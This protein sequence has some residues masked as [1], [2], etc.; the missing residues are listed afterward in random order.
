M[1]IMKKA[2]SR[3]ERIM[4]RVSILV[5]L[6]LITFLFSS[7]LGKAQD[8][9]NQEKVC[10]FY[11][12]YIGCPNCAYTDPTVLSE[13]PEEY[14]KFV[15]IEYSWIGGQLGD[16]NS[17]FFGEYAQAYKTQAAVPQLFFSKDNTKLGRLDVPKA[18]QDIK[19]LDSNPCPLIKKR[20]A[21]E[22]LSLNELKAK[23]KIWA[24][25]RILIKLEE[26]SWLFQWNGKGLSKVMIG[27]ERI[28]NSLAKDL[29]FTSN[30]SATLKDKKF[31]I[32]SP[33]KVKFSGSA[34]PTSS[35]F[36][37]Y[38]E[39]ENAIK[40]NV[41]KAPSAAST[42]TKLKQPLPEGKE[43]K[44]EEVDL[45]LFGK[46]KTKK[47][48]IPLLTAIFA[49]ADGLTNPCGFFVLFFLAG[50]LL[51]LA[52]ARKR[53]FLVGSVFV[54]FFIIYYFLFMALLLNVFMLGK[55]LALLTTIAGLVCL[56]AGFLN[57][58]DYFF[59]GKGF[60]L[61]LS[62]KKK[63]KFAE[64]VENLSLAKSNSALIISSIIVASAISL[65]AIACTFG[66]PLAYT[67]V[68]SAKS[69]PPLLYYLYLV[70]YNL[71]YSVPMLTI[72]SIIA[73]TLGKGQFGEAWIKKLK[74]ISGFIILFLGF[75]LIW[76]YIL[77]EHIGFILS[78]MFL[79]LVVSA[80]IIFINEIL[81]KKIKL[82]K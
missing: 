4:L 28:S 21:W 45:P 70:F 64:R 51:G 23:P 16:P 53:I 62:E 39:F 33:Y 35:G 5:I 31:E 25:K 71:I 47:F 2:T 43:K 48:S 49:V 74:L 59:F 68:L 50:S 18:E 46:I 73:I 60:S 66:I 40:I 8:A 19:G 67:K 24:N 34:F 72:V 80:L 69:L 12:T 37:P 63:S 54:L 38:I 65:V 52:G 3:K 22:Q 14:S 15:V 32:V 75:V 55:K 36:V 42:P 57:I 10:T 13:W 20:V 76:N 78:L 17:N 30:I 9:Q 58:K 1:K 27:N 7:P 79:A 41:I 61:S 81:I 77:L 44:I 56:F 6:F 29:L 82:K 26:S 11:F